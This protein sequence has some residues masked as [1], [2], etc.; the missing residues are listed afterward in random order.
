MPTHVD[1]PSLEPLY[2]NIQT[3][4]HHRKETLIKGP[5]NFCCIRYCKSKVDMS[6]VGTW[7]SRLFVMQ[8][9]LQG[10]LTRLPPKLRPRWFFLFS[11]ACFFQWQNNCHQ[12]VSHFLDFF[13]MSLDVAYHN[14]KISNI[15]KINERT[16]MTLCLLTWK[17]S[18]DSLSKKSVKIILQE[19]LCGVMLC[20]WGKLGPMCSCVCAV[21]G[22]GWCTPNCNILEKEKEAEGRVDANV[23]SAP[24]VHR[25]LL[26][27]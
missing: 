22:Q 14:L 25:A 10:L 11:K 26:W 15:L 7:K 16:A 12:T 19:K 17:V 8:E 21:K 27:C 3:G 2:E 13:S 24:H 9:N 20:L 4:F 1:P 6:V 5:N 23:K 18:H